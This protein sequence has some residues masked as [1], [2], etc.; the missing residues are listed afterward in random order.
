[1]EEEAISIITTS[2]VGLSGLTLVLGG[3]RSGKSRFAERLIG[4]RRGAAYI[5]TAEARDAEMQARIECH[6]K[7]RGPDWRTFEEPLD[8]VGA[9][10]RAAAQDGPILLDCLTVWLSNLMEAERDIA[11]EMQRLAGCLASPRSPV[12]VVSNEV[13]QGIVPAN[14]LAR[15]FRDH[16]GQLNQAI[17]AVADRV[18]F[19]TAG[20]ATQI[21]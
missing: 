17:A 6:R 7:R 12:V 13:G 3:A 19:V 4:D 8:L 2:D 15:R 21:K 1:M 5:A 16:A 9:F 11:D 20:L 18:Y 10:R 14:P